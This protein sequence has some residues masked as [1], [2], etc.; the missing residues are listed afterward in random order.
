MTGRAGYNE[1][2]QL[3]RAVAVVLVL[4]F[5]LE[6]S[7]FSFGYLGVDLFFLISGFL[8]PVILPKYDARSF[9]VARIE[10]IYPALIVVCLFTFAVG[11][12]F[13]IPL[14]YDGLSW[15]AISAIFSASNLYFYFNAG[16]FDQNTESQA[17]LH[18]WSLGNEFMCYVAVSI[19]LLLQKNRDRIARTA[20]ALALLSAAIFLGFLA[21]EGEGVNYFNPFPRIFLFFVAFYVSARGWQVGGAAAATIC[22]AAL[23]LLALVWGGNLAA[24]RYPSLSVFAI[25]AAGLPI[26]M[27]RQTV[28]LPA[29][30]RRPAVWL[31]DISYSVYLWH[32]PLIVFE[33]V[34]LRNFRL[35]VSEMLVLTAATLVASVLSYYLIERRRAFR[36]PA[37]LIGGSALVLAIG[38]AGAAT[39]GFS[40]RVPPEM[41]AY[42]ALENMRDDGTTAC[43]LEAAGLTFQT[44]C[45]RGGPFSRTVIFAG[46]SH[47]RH[48]LTLMERGEPET[49]VL[50]FAMPV[51]DGATKLQRLSEAADALAA[52]RVY[53]AYR[54]EIYEKERTAELIEGVTRLSDDRFKFVQEVPSY[55]FEPVSCYLRQNS[56]LMFEDC[57]YPIAKG[58]PLEGVAS[59]KSD[60]WNAVLS[61]GLPTL[62]THGAFC[63]ERKCRVV[64]DGKL[65][66]RD[67][68]HLNERLPAALQLRLYEAIFAGDR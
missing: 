59:R 41:S 50:Q 24:S 51:E 65:V 11:Y 22:G 38:A 43:S 54:H 25:A 67:E 32:W 53:L 42:S 66:M 30:V 28:P 6:V 29:L 14:E 45:G 3:L 39:S 9:I 48:F 40:S 61:A 19:V 35:N 31:G 56:D 52:D 20:L 62:G 68:N 55:H 7:A 2:I 15:S 44:R 18:T 21:V 10:R 5:H 63:D 49:R 27:L 16:Y 26:L 23:A 37:F 12:L 36:R 13:L 33:K 1:N 47:S 57:A 17:L 60:S 58:I 4:L 34:Y 46:D 64:I 8:M